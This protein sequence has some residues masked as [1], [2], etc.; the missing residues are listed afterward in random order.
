MKRASS[1]RRRQARWWS[2]TSTSALAISV[3][4]GTLILTAALVADERLARFHFVHWSG[5]G[6]LSGGGIASENA[7]QPVGFSELPPGDPI[8]RFS[9]T[10]VGQ[11][12]FAVSQS[13][14]CRRVLFNN[15]TGAFYEA[16]EIYCGE[17]PDQSDETVGSDRLSELRQFFRR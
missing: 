1:S 2:A 6:N 10:G 4:F 14:N 3:V 7:G 13:D 8:V 5:G 12:L 15:R 16:K 9:D 11:I 17:K